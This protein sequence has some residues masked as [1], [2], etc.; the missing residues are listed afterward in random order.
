MWRYLNP[1]GIIVF[2]ICVQ[3]L[4]STLN[5]AD[6]INSEPVSKARERFSWPYEKKIALKVDWIYILI[7]NGNP[8]RVETISLDKNTR[9]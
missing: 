7:V 9:I 6:R 8:K 4:E 1:D 5:I 2:N 3:E